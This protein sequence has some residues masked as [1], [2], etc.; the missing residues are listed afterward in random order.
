M[1]TH[2]K[3]GVKPEEKYERESEDASIGMPILIMK[4]RC[5]K[6]I[7]ANVAPARGRDPYAIERVAQ[8]IGLLGHKKISTKD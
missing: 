5:A 4:D 7:F 3:V 6:A 1:H 2:T 8:Y